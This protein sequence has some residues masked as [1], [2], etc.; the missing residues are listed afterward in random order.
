VKKQDR[1]SITDL[2]QERLP[3][4]LN[5][6]VGKI[7]LIITTEEAGPLLYIRATRARCEL[8]FQWGKA[9]TPMLALFKLLKWWA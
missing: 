9:L 8:A 2:S 6:A 5:Q 1:K 3:P 4:A 7:E